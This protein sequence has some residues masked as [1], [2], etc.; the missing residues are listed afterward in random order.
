MVIHEEWKIN[1]SYFKMRSERSTSWNFVGSVILCRQAQQKLPIGVDRRRWRSNILHQVD[2]CSACSTDAACSACSTVAAC[3][4]C[5]TDAACS[6]CSTEAACSA[7]STDAACSACSTD[8]ACPAC[9]TDAACSACS[10]D[11]ACSACSTDV[12]PLL[13]KVRNCSRNN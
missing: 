8:A 3:S 11:A 5:S 4:A 9:S 12:E 13:V 2:A 6:A 7:Y 1:Y 10:T